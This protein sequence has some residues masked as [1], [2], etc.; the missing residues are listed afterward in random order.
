MMDYVIPKQFYNVLETM[1]RLSLG[2][3]KDIKEVHFFND[4][5]VPAIPAAGARVKVCYAGVCL[6]DREVKNTKQARITCGIKDTSLF[7]GYEVAGVIESFGA[8][9][10]PS[11]YDLQ[12]GDQVVVWPTDEMCKY[13]YA[14]FVSVPTLDFLVK[15]PVSF[16]MHVAAMLPAGATWAYSAILQS[17]PIIDAFCQSKG[18]CNV[19]IVGAGGLGLWLLRMCRFYLSLHSEQR[20]NLLVAD[21]KE[22]RLSLA[23]RNGADRV[24]HWDESEFEEHLITRT[25]DAARSGLQI[26]FDFVT[27]P[28]TVTR[29]LRCLSEGGVLFVGGLSG[30]DVQLP[31]KLLAKRHLSIIGVSRGSIELLKSLVQLIDA[32]K[33]DPPSYKVYPIT[34]AGSVMKQ[35][36]MSEVEGRAILE[37]CNPEKALALVKTNNSSLSNDQV[38]A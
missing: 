11:S 36:S 31:V 27:S 34:Q 1:R 20:I 18:H 14:D 23:E 15:I 7:P 26:V 9:A 29:S 6:T 13:G 16:S 32:G 38:L 22:E 8:D 33:V 28:R 3:P 4:V 30:L 35:L 21:G 25:K 37:V 10:D 5:P 2:S 24:V 12:L 19:L 17:S